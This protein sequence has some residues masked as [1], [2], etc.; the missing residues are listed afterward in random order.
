MAK[1]KNAL[2]AMHSKGEIFNRQAWTLQP[3][4]QYLPCND[5]EHSPNGDRTPYGHVIGG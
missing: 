1:E 2:D 5:D 3:T 4:P